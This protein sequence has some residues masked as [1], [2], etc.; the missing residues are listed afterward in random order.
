[1]LE[2]TP[3]HDG[4]RLKPRFLSILKRGIRQPKLPR[5]FDN[6]QSHPAEGG[7]LMIYA[8]HASIG[9]LSIGAALVGQLAGEQI[10]GNLQELLGCSH[11]ASQF[12]RI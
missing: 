11:A 1:M 10:R 7:K 6:V 2:R 4:G 8:S 3:D 5:C 9:V 12:A